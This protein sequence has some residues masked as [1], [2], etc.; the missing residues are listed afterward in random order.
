MKQVRSLCFL[1]I[2]F[3]CVGCVANTQVRTQP[4]QGDPVAE[5]PRMCVG[6]TYTAIE[7]SATTTNRKDEFT[8]TVDKVN[9]DGSFDFIMTSKTDNRKERLL[10]NNDFQLIKWIDLRD[11]EIKPTSEPPSKPLKFPLFVGKKWKDHYKG[12]SVDDTY[13]E[14]TNTYF[15]TDY[16]KMSFDIG[17]Y[18]VFRIEEKQWNHVWSPSAKPSTKIKYY[19]PKLKIVIK[20]IPS[21]RS[22][23]Y[24]IDASMKKCN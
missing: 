5:F 19:S 4:E 12:K 1:F 17:T 9:P 13:Y 15:V 6:D 16:K 23:D 20:A 21:W 22:N 2:A 10:Y 8:Y 14:Y 18:Y 24:V 7:Y 3:F 11:G